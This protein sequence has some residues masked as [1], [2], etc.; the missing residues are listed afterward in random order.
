M[1]NFIWLLP[2]LGF[3]FGYQLLSFLTVS[4]ELVVPSL[5]GL[6]LTQ[7]VKLL[8]DQNLNV[9][10]MAEKEDRDLEPGTVL[11]QTPAPGHKAKQN[12][13]IFLVLSKKPKKIFAP[14]LLTKPQ[15]EV[16]HTLNQLN[17]RAKTYTLSYPAPTGTC[18]GQLPEEKEVVHDNKMILY[19]SSGKSSLML[20]PNFKGST[21][22][23]VREQVAH[24]PMQFKLFHSQPVDE[25]HQCTACV[26]TDQKPL[27]GSLVDVRLPI[28]IQLQV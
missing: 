27:P 21:V 6:P 1:K 22:Q 12:Q 20:F 7:T 9:R 13:P 3:L 26:I 18:I 8:S 25:G 17:L 5:I 19:V 4:S 16:N 28:V 10:I 2:F 14:H 15:D 24:Y 11:S 23:E